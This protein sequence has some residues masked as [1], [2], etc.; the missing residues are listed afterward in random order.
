MPTVILVRHG[1]SSANTAGVLAGRAPGVHLDETGVTQAG[2]VGDRL[3]GVRLA[4]A[5]T[6]P[7]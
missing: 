2:A 5:V 6:R 3:A 1:R 4:S 7:L